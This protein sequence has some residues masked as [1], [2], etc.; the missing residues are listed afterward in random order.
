MSKLPFA[1]TVGDIQNRGDITALTKVENEYFPDIKAW[2]EKFLNEMEV[3]KINEL[4]HYEQGYSRTSLFQTPLEQ[5]K[6]F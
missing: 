6:G 5:I 3:T 2:I 1:D 4:T